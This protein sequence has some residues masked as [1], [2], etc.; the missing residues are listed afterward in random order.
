[1]TNIETSFYAKGDVFYAHL[2]GCRVVRSRTTPNDEGLVL[3]VDE[4]GQVVGLTVL[5][6][7]GLSPELWNE[8]PDRSELPQSLAEAFDAWLQS[9]SR[10]AA[11]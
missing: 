3:G 5:D 7:S 10:A 6:A 9:A 4:A 2:Q 8:H 11:P 1:M